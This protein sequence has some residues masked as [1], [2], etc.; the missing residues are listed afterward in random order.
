MA[1]TNRFRTDL[2]P[3][4]LKVGPYARLRFYSPTPIETP[5]QPYTDSGATNAMAQPVV[6]N[7]D[8]LFPE[9]YIKADERYIAE[10]RDA[11]GRILMTFGP[12]GPEKPERLSDIAK[13]LAAERGD[14]VVMILTAKNAGYYTHRSTTL[15]IGTSE[16]L[17]DPRFDRVLRM[18]QEAI[19]NATPFVIN[20]E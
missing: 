6:A 3:N 13:R 11:N 20:W 15:S 7:T 5:V 16:E 17:A 9:I 18:A 8:G 10:L 19:R 14:E 1:K 2:M 12:L 4:A